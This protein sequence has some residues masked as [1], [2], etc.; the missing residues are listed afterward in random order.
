LM[1][2]SLSRANE[3]LALVEPILAANPSDSEALRVVHQ[4]LSVPE[5]PGRWKAAHGPPQ[6]IV[7]AAVMR[8]RPT[9]PI[10]PLPPRGRSRLRA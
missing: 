9:K 1:I 5:S 6:L 8:R 4:A 2:G 10:L 3:A 7:A